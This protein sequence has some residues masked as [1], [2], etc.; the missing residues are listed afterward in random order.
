MLLSSLIIAPFTFFLRDNRLSELVEAF[1]DNA[2]VRDMISEI[3]ISEEVKIFIASEV[4]TS[5]GFSNTIILKKIEE[6]LSTAEEDYIRV[7]TLAKDLGLSLEKAL[8]IEE[9]LTIDVCNMT[10]RLS[11]LHVRRQMAAEKVVED[12][13]LPGNERPWFWFLWPF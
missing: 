7:E 3:I 9:K 4:I 13:L 6:D 12:S 10:A 5:L 1:H 8:E 2:F 11:E